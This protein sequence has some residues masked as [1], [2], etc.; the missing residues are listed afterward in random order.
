MSRFDSNASNLI[1]QL[2]VEDVPAREKKGIDHK[3][4]LLYSTIDCS[5]SITCVSNSRRPKISCKSSSE[6]SLNKVI[7]T[8]FN[9]DSILMKNYNYY[10]DLERDLD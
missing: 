7:I 4:M 10:S 8:I 6:S 1:T 2:S 9:I 3:N 5:L